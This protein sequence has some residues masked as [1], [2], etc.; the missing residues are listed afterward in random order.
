MSS[1]NPGMTTRGSRANSQVTSPQA[2]FA[3]NGN[4]PANS[5]PGSRR[6]SAEEHEEFVNDDFPLLRPAVRN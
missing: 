5:M 6:G 1:V 3:N 4:L 2:N